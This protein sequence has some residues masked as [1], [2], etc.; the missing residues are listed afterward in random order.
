MKENMNSNVQKCINEQPGRTPSQEP[1]DCP[2]LDK[3]LSEH[4]D[5]FNAEPDKKNAHTLKPI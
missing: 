1:R 3:R 2:S 4:F 5:A